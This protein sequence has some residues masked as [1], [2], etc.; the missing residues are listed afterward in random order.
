[1]VLSV[2]YSRESLI[3]EIKNL[4]LYKLTQRTFLSIGR[5]EKNFP[6]GEGL[7]GNNITCHFNGVEYLTFC[8]SVSTQKNELDQ[9]F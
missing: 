9:R 2:I 3:P 6:S 4:S 1:M 5:G 8:K 7:W